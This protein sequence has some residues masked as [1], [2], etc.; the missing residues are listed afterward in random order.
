[1]QITA[2]ADLPAVNLPVLA[3]DIVYFLIMEVARDLKNYELR[4]R[5][6]R[7]S[8]IQPNRFPFL[9]EALNAVQSK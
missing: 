6:Q 5:T 3:T 9:I 1:M 4:S 8:G 7:E 2:I